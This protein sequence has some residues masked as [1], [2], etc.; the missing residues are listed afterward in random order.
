[1]GQST[2]ISTP[3]LIHVLEAHRHVL[4]LPGLLRRGHLA[5]ELLLKLVHV[6]GGHGLAGQAP[7]FAVDV[8]V[9]SSTL[10]LGGDHKR[11]ELLFRGIHIV[12]GVFGFDDVGVCIDDCHGLSTSIATHKSFLSAPRR[13]PRYLD[14]VVGEGRGAPKVGIL[15]RIDSLH[16]GLSPH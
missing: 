11:P 16:C 12:P 3:K 6:W 8:P 15:T 13:G 5:A 1:M 2:W 9:F 10:P 14:Q 4:A 7:N